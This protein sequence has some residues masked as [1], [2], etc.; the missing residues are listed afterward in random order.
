MHYQRLAR[1]KTGAEFGPRNYL[2]SVT[3]LDDAKRNLL[4]GRR[5]QIVC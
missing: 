1:S 4:A 5:L 3:E 2:F